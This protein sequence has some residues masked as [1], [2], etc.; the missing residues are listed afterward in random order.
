MLLSPPQW[1]LGGS[2]SCV[3]MLSAD[4]RVQPIFHLLHPFVSEARIWDH[5]RI[6]KSGRAAH[7]PHTH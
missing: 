7:A 4:L 1:L 6:D 5:V 2:W 3:L